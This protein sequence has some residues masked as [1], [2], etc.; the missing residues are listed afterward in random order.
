[1]RSY[2][3]KII[4]NQDDAINNIV[5]SLVDHYRSM[6]LSYDPKIRDKIKI[7]KNNIFLIGRSGSG[8]TLIIKKACEYL[9]VPFVSCDINHLVPPGYVGRK[10]DDVVIDLFQKAENSQVLFSFGIIF[11]DEVDKILMDN[12]GQQNCK[13]NKK[14]LLLSLLESE[15]ITVSKSNNNLQKINIKSILFIG[16]GSFET[17]DGKP[18]NY[19]Q[20]DINSLANKTSSIEVLSRFYEKIVLNVPTEDN[21]INEFE[22]QLKILQKAYEKY[23]I[24]IRITK[25]NLR[26]YF[27]NNFSYRTVNELRYS[28]QKKIKMFFTFNDQKTYK[29]FS[30]DLKINNNLINEIP[31]ELFVN[32]LTLNDDNLKEIKKI[33]ID[34]L[35]E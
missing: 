2:L 10:I 1:M 29:D 18:A 8:K 21:L 16:A 14:D 19:K 26:K 12:S 11:F 15:E 3:K 30:I 5:V 7:F 27:N 22:N 32:D 31:I 34:L 20:I 28:V 25:E 23:S 13:V 4:K 35:E 9:G 33:N 24:A 6:A 17:S